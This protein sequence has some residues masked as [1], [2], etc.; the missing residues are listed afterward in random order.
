[1]CCC[2]MKNYKSCDQNRKRTTTKWESECFTTMF[3][4]SLSLVFFHSF[5]FP[6]L[7]QRYLNN[8]T[9]SIFSLWEAFTRFTSRSPPDKVFF[10]VCY[11]FFSS[12]IFSLSFYI[13]I[14]EIKNLYLPFIDERSKLMSSFYT[15]HQ[16]ELCPR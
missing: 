5:T 9:H 6:C 10:G 1:M 13:H 14:K 3:F 15:L 4:P 8:G 7:T 11:N 12:I 2:R 16:R